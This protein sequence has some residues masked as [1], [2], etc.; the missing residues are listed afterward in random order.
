MPNDGELLNRWIW[1]IA[2]RNSDTLKRI[3]VD[4]PGNFLFYPALSPLFRI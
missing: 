1:E 4:T 3:L 2:G